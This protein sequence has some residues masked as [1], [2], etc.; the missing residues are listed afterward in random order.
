MSVRA[1]ARETAC[2]LNFISY[3]ACIPFA[4]QS[5]LGSI[6]LCTHILLTHLH[7]CEDPEVIL[8][9]VSQDVDV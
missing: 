5:K 2:M 1:R 3:A 9:K 6:Q 7:G 4:V 8:G